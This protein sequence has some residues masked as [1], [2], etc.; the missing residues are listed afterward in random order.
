MSW[1]IVG[2]LA[3]AAFLMFF[4]LLKKLIKLAFSLLLFILL[5]IG[6][7]YVMEENPDM[8]GDHRIQSVPSRTSYAEVIS[9]N[10]SS[11]RMSSRMR[12]FCTLPV[13]VVGNESTN[14]M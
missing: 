2:F 13:T 6:I 3:L 5:L 9:S 14:L 1:I 10:P 8:L 11:C 7:W 12:N 4:S